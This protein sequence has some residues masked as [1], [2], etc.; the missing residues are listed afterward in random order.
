MGNVEDRDLLKKEITIIGYA[1][2]DTA[3]SKMPMVVNDYLSANDIKAHLIGISIS[4]DD[5]NFFIKN[6]KDSKVEVTIFSP[7]YQKRAADFY[8]LNGYLIAAFKKDGEFLLVQEDKELF[9]DDSKMIE[10]I[11]K[12]VRE[13]ER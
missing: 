2:E 7:E 8:D 1:G 9:F 12:I 4:E 3:N 10:V 13:R 5:F 6:L 11:K